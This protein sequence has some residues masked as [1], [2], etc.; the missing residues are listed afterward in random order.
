[1]QPVNRFDLV[2]RCQL[3]GD[4]PWVASSASSGCHMVPG[5]QAGLFSLYQVGPLPPSSI[6]YGPGQGLQLW[7]EGGQWR[8]LWTPSAG[9]GALAWNPSH[10]PQHPQLMLVPSWC[11]RSSHLELRLRTCQCHQLWAQA[12]ASAVVVSAVDT[13]SRFRFGA[14]EPDGYAYS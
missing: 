7:W 14:L 4:G 8:Q 11:N 10:P 6:S 13:T 12:G 5:G 1:M 9:S 3:T 2:H